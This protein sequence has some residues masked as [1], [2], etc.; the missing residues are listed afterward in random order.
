[1]R[2][3]IDTIRLPNGLFVTLSED[4]TAP[5]VAVNLWYHVGSANE[6]PG[7]TGF[8]HLFEHML[9]QG[10]ADVEANEHFE[11]IQRAGGT[12]NGSTWLERT[13][14]FET[15]PSN[16]LELALWLE[17][18]RM[19]KLLPAMTQQK[20][21]TQREVVMNERRWTMDNQPYGTWL[22]KLPALCFPP[23]H[24]FHHS[25]IGSMEDLTAASLDDVAQFFATYYTPDNAVLSVAGDFEPATAIRLIERHFGNI[26]RGSGRP[27]LPDM[28]LPPVFGQW[29]REVSPDEIMLPRLFLAFRSPAFGTPD[30]YAASVC[31]AVLGLRNGSR[32]RR[33]LMRERQVAA[34]AT[35]FTF[36]LAKGSDL[37]VVDVTARPGIGAE[38]LE[39]EVAYEIDAVLRD[40]ISAM[41]L[42][43][44]IALVQTSFVS[45]MQQAGER[46][47]RLSLFATYFG[48]PRLVNEEVERYQA[49]TVDDINR[50]A[51]ERLGENNRA[52]LL[53]VPRDDAPGELVGAGAA[54]EE[55]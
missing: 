13:N 51:R 40:G 8:A 15:V 24:P 42:E 50:F 44:A 46:A 30:Y 25:L 41:E 27:A 23:E 48:E 7:R 26:P 14:Y 38:Q 49:V 53:Y 5:I 6:R 29:K 18:N 39:Q 11:L 32:L 35:A 34:E 31:G 2:I 19:G 4:H 12:L 55:Q 16:Q 1:M 36:D 28:S 52:S 47:D 37:L 43:R 10:S 20:L 3:P 17:A 21:D 22:E 9:F 45:S 54:A 33:R